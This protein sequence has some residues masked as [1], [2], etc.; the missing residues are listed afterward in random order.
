MIFCRSLC[1]KIVQYILLNCQNESVI[2][3]ARAPN[4]FSS[5]FSAITYSILM[6]FKRAKN[7]FVGN[8]K[9]YTMSK[10]KLLNKFII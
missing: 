2:Q 1:K 9:D 4:Y 7:H 3:R 5:S 10:V 8:F 6:I